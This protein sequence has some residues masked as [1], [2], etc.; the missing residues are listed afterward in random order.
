MIRNYLKSS[1]RS[2]VK[3]K[4]FSIINILGL[5]LGMAA[6]LMIIQFTSFEQSYDQYHAKKD[7]LFRMQLN[8]YNAG[9]ISTQWASGCAAIGNAL[10]DNFPEVENVAKFH[11]VDA[12]ISFGP[13]RFHET[14]IYFA[15]PSLFDMFTI[16]IVMGDKETMFDDP[17]SVVISESMAMKYFGEEDPIGKALSVNDNRTAEVT[18]V[19]QDLP[20]NTHL[21]FSMLIPWKRYEDIQGEDINTAWQWDGFITY[22]ELKEQ[23]DPLAFQAKIPELVEREQGEELEQYNAGMEFILQPIDEIFLTSNY[24]GEFKINGNGNNVRSLIIIAVFIIVIGWVNYIN[25]S[26]SKSMERAREVGIRKVM[27]SARSQLLWQFMMESF[28]T[29]LIAIL[30]AAFIV[31]ISW[32]SFESFIEK[33]ITTSLLTQPTFWAWTASLIVGGTLF[34]GFYPSLILSSFKPSTVL[35]GKFNNS[36]GGLYLRKG[37]VI[38][39]FATSMLLIVGTLS[40]YKQITFMK[41]QDLGVNI[42]QT[43]I[44]SA[45]QI[46][47][48][49]Y[50]NKRD[51]FK[52]EVLKIPEIQ[53]LAISNEVPGR[54]V[55]WNAGGVRRVGEN[56]SQANQYRIMVVDGDFVSA[57]EI[58]VLAGR[59]FS[60][61]R[62]NEHANVLFNESAIER[63]GFESMEEAIDKDI[64][65]WGDTFKIVGVVADYHQQSLKTS[66]DPLI[67][68][69]QP[70]WGSYFS[71]KIIGDDYS[72][73]ISKLEDEFKAT[74]PGNPYEYF[75]LDEHFDQQY[76]SDERFGNVFTLF[77]ILAVTIACMG[78][79]GLAAYETSLRVKEIGVRKTLGASMKSLFALMSKDF[80]LLVFIG[81]M[82]AAPVAYFLLSEW[83]QN[84]ANAISIQWWLFALPLMVLL[85]VS[86]GTVSYHTIRA[87]TVNP[88]ESLRHE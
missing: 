12:V 85:I 10:K 4:V 17:S 3:Q 33:S 7:R 86:I 76:K 65:F 57:Y 68:R 54:K 5:A 63:M 82:V 78:L 50:A 31:M 56:E 59:N 75:F 34:A 45:P 88:A 71:L 58:D 42:D 73:I 61:E 9:E 16:P 26:T 64:W 55:G 67:Y 14:E 19:F 79:F 13:N 36:K 28:L 21:S 72:N 24:I 25:L 62:S 6:F 44:V 11:E 84:F 40:V 80:S 38:F 83:L 70:D 74:F 51:V 47:D 32:N 8:R 48:S 22:I 66:F 37:L 20:E 81:A 35:K 2:L 41:S 1:Y 39:Q 23:V 69:Y 49:T 43:L 15:T 52:N 29:N 77:A 27:G 87:A 60:D 46:T 18:G 53:S 30:L